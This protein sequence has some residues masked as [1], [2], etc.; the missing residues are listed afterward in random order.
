MELIGPADA[1]YDRHRTVANQ[2]VG[3]RP[4]AIARCRTRDDVVAALAYGAEHG[5][6][7]A[8]RG[9]AASARATVDGGLVVDVSPMKAVSIDAARRVARVAGGVTWAELDAAAEP[10]G[11]A[12]TGA[13]VSWLGVTG[14][15][16]SGGSGW[17]E[18]SLGPTRASVIGAEVVRADGSVATVAEPGP[19]AVVTELE[20]RLHPTGPELL[21]GFLSFPRARAREVARAYRDYMAAAPDAVAGGLLLFAGRGG[22]CQI[23]FC[24]AGPVAAG[25]QALAPLRALGPSLDAVTP[26]RYT[27]LQA[28]TDLHHPFGSRMELRSGLLRGLPD[29]VIDESIAMADRPA[30]AL[31]RLLLRPRGGVLDRPEAP[32]AYQCLGLWPP[33]ASLDRGNLEWVAGVAGA[34]SPVCA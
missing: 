18:R 21:A 11:L 12:V 6:P 19:G 25:V 8:V 16:R 26:N 15:A 7:V 13:R 9:G 14:V 1:G 22:A 4:A 3:A 20:L 17:L 33:V 30:A 32:W 10:H 24:F 31:S 5:L 29:A 34:F 23:V 2:R 27:A 28:M